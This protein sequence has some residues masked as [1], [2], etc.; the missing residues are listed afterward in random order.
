MMQLRILSI[1]RSIVSVKGKRLSAGI[2]A[3]MFLVYLAAPVSL[4]AAATTPNTSAGT[5]GCALNRP[6]GASAGTYSF[7]KTT[8][9]WQNAHYTWDPATCKTQPINPVTYTYNYTTGR[10]D[11]T[12]WRYNP[13]AKK[14]YQAKAAVATPPSGPNYVL[15]KPA[16]PAPAPSSS[17]A[18]ANNGATAGAS[19]SGASGPNATNQTSSTANNNDNTSDNSTATVNN[20]INANGQSGDA[21]V[22]NNT[23]GGSAT[24]GDTV[25]TADIL[26][27]LQSNSSLT[28]AANPPI[29][30]VDNVNGTVNGNLLVDPSSVV[31]PAGGSNQLVTTNNV[32]TTD[33]N[34]AQITNNVQLASKSGNA[35]VAGNTKAGNATS[36]NADA[37]AN[38]V[39][40]IN[41]MIAS[42]QSF[43]GVI[44]IL[45]DLNGNILLPS[46]FYNSLIASNAPS[47]T[48]N[49]KNT[50]NNNIAT[51]LNNNQS[52]N[53]VVTTTA[54][55]GLASTTGNTKAGNATSGQAT[56]NVTVFNL[57]GDQVVSNNTLLVFVNVL[58][59]WVGMLLNAPAGS[60]AAAYGGGVT[61]DTTTQTNNINTKVNNNDSINN[62]INVAATSGNA[63]VTGNTSAG[64]ATS[65]NANAAANL[66]NVNNSSFASADWFGILF[67]NV[68]GD[69]TGNFGLQPLP[70]KS[71]NKTYATTSAPLKPASAKT[72]LAKFNNFAA[73][74]TGRPPITTASDT[75]SNPNN[76]QTN[77][78]SGSVLAASTTKKP[79][80]IDTPVDQATSNTQA[81]QDR[82][83][84]L[85]IGLIIVAV[86]LGLFALERVIS[87]KTRAAG[88]ND[89][90]TGPKN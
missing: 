21:A 32:N 24:S 15:V 31:Q 82:Y 9:L 59:K 5:H 62:N 73:A 83:V 14:F 78:L 48:I 81:N 89:K 7:N 75:T 35:K 36:G 52:I 51:T 38:V 26:N 70:P 72:P 11:A 64:N 37:V 66:L 67:I 84:N 57:T 79:R 80:L 46:Q 65:G 3:L 16:P 74:V 45:G 61:K 47:S 54:K 25:T 90:K 58:G 34:T 39:N 12:V 49:V 18:N 76:G 20:D 56:T 29:T 22:Q 13:A 23:A 86:G 69:W 1:I 2:T 71:L 6:T 88:A 41:S 63:D 28:V 55:T 17:N 19:S 4:A 27:S 85:K 53:N 43:V 60:T 40:M 8:G 68:F 77:S 50:Q 33:N 87:A 30:F 44:N 42:K 10:W